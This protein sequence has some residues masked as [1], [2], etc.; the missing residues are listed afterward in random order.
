MVHK[1]KI[2]IIYINFTDDAIVKM[3]NICFILSPC[4]EGKIYSLSNW[5]FDDC[6]I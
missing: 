4:S 1:T 2:Q 5:V 6:I 3:K